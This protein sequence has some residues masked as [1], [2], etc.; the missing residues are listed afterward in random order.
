MLRTPQFKHPSIARADNDLLRTAR[1]MAGQSDRRLRPQIIALHDLPGILRACEFR[2]KHFGIGAVRVLN[3]VIE[4]GRVQV[5]ID[6]FAP[7]DRIDAAE[8]IGTGQESGHKYDDYVLDV[9]DTAIIRWRKPAS[10]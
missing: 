1:S 2:L 3:T 9:E 8:W 4:P 10:L 6:Y 5:T 7:L